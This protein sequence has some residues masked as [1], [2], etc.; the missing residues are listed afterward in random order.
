M[1]FVDLI[2]WDLIVLIL[3][4]HRAMVSSS[5]LQV[6]ILHED[7]LLRWDSALICEIALSI[8]SLRLVPISLEQTLLI[9]RN[10]HTISFVLIEIS[11]M[12]ELSLR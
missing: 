11:P 5:C 12:N 7:L 3:L 2:G 4:H 1:L 6:L 8:V 9:G 10:T